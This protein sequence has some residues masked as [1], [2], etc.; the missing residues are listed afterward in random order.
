MAELE[1]YIQRKTFHLAVYHLS[2][3]DN[4]KLQQRIALARVKSWG[5]NV[6]MEV[7]WRRSL[8]SALPE[9]MHGIVKGRLAGKRGLVGSQL[10]N[11]CFA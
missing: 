2:E 4:S 9:S 1:Q 7:S 6:G 8:V 10:Y 3:S 5:R 11:G